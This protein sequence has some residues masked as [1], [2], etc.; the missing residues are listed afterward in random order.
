MLTG[1]PIV[2]SGFTGSLMVIAVN[3]WMNHPTGFTLTDGARVDV[4]PFAAL[5]ENRYFW[6]ELIHM[7]LAAYMVAGFADRERVRVGAGCAG[8]D[9]RYNRIALIIPLTVAALAAPVQIVVGD[10]A[11]R[12]VAE[13]QPVKLAALEGLATTDEGR[14]RAPARL[15]RRR[16]GR[17]T[18]SR[19]RK[20]LSLLAFHDPNA[21]VKGLDTVPAAERPPV[22]VVRF[23]FQTMV[24][25]GTALALLG[26]VFVAHLARGGGGC[27][28]RRWFYRAVV[29]AG[30]ALGRR[31]DRR[32]DHDRGRAASPGSSTA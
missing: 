14:A 28:P 7:Y 1:L 18:G 31:A 26:V 9:T 24:G 29:A 8:G 25:I 3:G 32:L 27:R 20:L 21:E 2:I 19:S 16:R 17:S 13:T 6:H 10:W 12:D 4:H 15:V 5:F 23:A 11:A 30:P 22:N